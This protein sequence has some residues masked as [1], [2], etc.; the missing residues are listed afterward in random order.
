MKISELIQELEV[1]RAA[2]GD[3]E[4]YANFGCWC[5]VYPDEPEVR[6]KEQEYGDPEGLYLN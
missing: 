4:V 2:L 1:Q 5:C 3:I 6:F